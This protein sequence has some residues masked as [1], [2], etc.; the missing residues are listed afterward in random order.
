MK[1][2]GWRV[3]FGPDRRSQILLYVYCNTHWYGI[4]FL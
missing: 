1:N 2:E 4:D 3:G